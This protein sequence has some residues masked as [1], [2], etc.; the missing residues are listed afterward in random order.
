MEQ[1]CYNLTKGAIILFA[2]THDTFDTVQSQNL[3]SIQ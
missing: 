3:Y 2:P 1:T